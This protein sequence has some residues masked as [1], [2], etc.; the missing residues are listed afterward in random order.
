VF[1]AIVS[2]EKP[3][4]CKDPGFRSM[5]KVIPD[6]AGASLVSDRQL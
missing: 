1:S 5:R 6:T 2:S 3:Y 4:L